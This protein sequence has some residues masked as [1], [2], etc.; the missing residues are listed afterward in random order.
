MTGTTIGP[1]ESA[2]FE[3]PHGIEGHPDAVLEVRWLERAWP[4]WRA[5]VARLR[6]GDLVGAEGLDLPA[7][8][9]ASALGLTQAH[10]ERRL[11]AKE[12]T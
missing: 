1:G 10:A 2:S 7:D 12:A 5:N 9:E 6:V 3:L 4:L 8:P 11:G